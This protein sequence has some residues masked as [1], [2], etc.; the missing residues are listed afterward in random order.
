MNKLFFIIG[1]VV[2]VLFFY[3]CLSHHSID[4]Q[5]D[6]EKK[7]AL[8]IQ[9]HQADSDV[10]QA[11][12]GRDVTLTGYVLSQE[13]KEKAEKS[14]SFVEGARTI[15]NNIEVREPRPVTQEFVREVDIASVIV[16]EPEL[17]LKSVLDSSPVIDENQ[18]EIDECQEKL[19]ALIKDKKINFKTAQAVIRSDSFALLNKIVKT[20][21]GCSGVKLQI[22]GHTDSSGN[23]D[24]NLELSRKRAKSVGYYLLKKGVKQQVSVIKH[25]S[26]M[27]IASNDTPEGR[28]K[29]RRIEFKV[30]KIDE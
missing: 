23:R 22:H 19:S 21:E 24:V 15:I 12:D 11:V 5:N 26:D 16:T 18:Q 8:A 1:S 3:H 13:E 27:P 4:I 9:S 28:S 20:M 14:I 7:V 25:G 2:T 17:E 30:K 29:N 10:Q 6:V